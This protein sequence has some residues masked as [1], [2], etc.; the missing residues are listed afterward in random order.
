MA[1]L[2]YFIGIDYVKKLHKWEIMASRLEARDKAYYNI[3][4]LSYFDMKKCKNCGLR[5]CS[6]KL[7]TFSQGRRNFET[8]YFTVDESNNII[9]GTFKKGTLP[10][11]CGYKEKMLLTDKDFEIDI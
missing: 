2:G 4:N 5:K 1:G 9:E 8:I 10:Y 6:L 3:G 11:T 7:N